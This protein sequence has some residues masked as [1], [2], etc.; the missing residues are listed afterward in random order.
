MEAIGSNRAELSNAQR[1]LHELQKDRANQWDEENQMADEEAHHFDV[2]DRL[3]SQRLE[4]MD[5]VLSRPGR[6][7][8]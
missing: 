2:I 3:I 4:E 6:I 5:R 8:P 1:F 7:Y